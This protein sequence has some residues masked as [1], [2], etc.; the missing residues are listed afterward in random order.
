MKSAAL[1][2][3]GIIAVTLQARQNPVRQFEV[4]S[5][6]PTT[7]TAGIVGGRGAP[8]T[9]APGSGPI[10][11]RGSD[12][13]DV[14]PVPAGTCFAVSATLRTVIARAYGVGLDGRT[15][16]GGSGWIDSDAYRIEAKAAEPDKTTRAQLLLM[17]RTLLADRF[18]LRI[19]RESRA[20]PWYALSIAK[21]GSKLKEALDQEVPRI[22]NSQPG[23]FV[24]QKTTMATFVRSLTFTLGQPVIDETGLQGSYSFT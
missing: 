15:I 17:L 6:R 13:G 14:T 1:T 8:G 23:T 9:G 19:N 10:L 12:A 22:A 11:C 18:K 5:V 3:N 2:M 4:A 20:V 7:A 21:S 24:V 16:L